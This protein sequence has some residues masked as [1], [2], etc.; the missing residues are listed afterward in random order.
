MNARKEKTTKLE[1]NISENLD[2][3][4]SKVVDAF[5]EIESPDTKNPALPDISMQTKSNMANLPLLYQ[6]GL[7]KGAH[8][9]INLMDEMLHLVSKS[10]KKEDRLKIRKHALTES[11]KFLKHIGLDKKNK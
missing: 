6:L 8:G 10:I 3:L 5:T 7:K 9:G 4:L 11:N 1:M 2:I